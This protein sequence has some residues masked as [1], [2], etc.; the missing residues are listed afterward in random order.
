MKFIIKSIVS[1]ILVISMLLSASV[2]AFAKSEEIYLSELRIVYANSYDEAKQVLTSSK[3]EDYQIFNENLNNGSGEVGVW[4]AYKTTTNIED[5]ITDIAIM[6]MGGGYSEGNF[7]EMIKASKEEYTAMG[8]IYLEAID[9]FAEAYEAG[10][11]LAG[12]AYRQ[13]NFYAGLDNYKDERLGDLFTEGVLTSSDLAT[14]F[15]QGNSYVLRNIRSLLAMGV[16]YNKEGMHYLQRVSMIASGNYDGYVD[17]SVADLTAEDISLSDS[18]DLDVLTALIAP[19]ITVFRNMFEELAAYEAELNYDD[20]EFTEL[21]VEY[22]EYKAM[23]DMMRAVEYLDGQSLYDFCMNYAV[24]KNDYSAL[25]PLAKALNEG[26]VAMTKVAHYYDVVRY[27]MTESP[28][29]VI[30][31]QLVEL[32]AKYAEKAF[33]VYTGVDRDMY[34]G[35][36]AL[37]S[38]AYRA[39]AYTDSV[40]LSEALFG[41]ESLMMTS[42]QIAAGA[43][44]IGLSVW[45]IVRTAKG[46]FGGT[47]EVASRA[48]GKALKKLNETAMN[49]AERAVINDQWYN[50]TV[51]T[52]FVDE[53]ARSFITDAQANLFNGDFKYTFGNCTERLN[54]INQVVAEHPEA[55]ENSVRVNNVKDAFQAYNKAYN[56][57]YKSGLAKAEASVRSSVISARIFTGAL[58]IFGAASTA[59]SAVSLYNKIH[60]Y[61]NPT[62][63]VVPE[64]LVDLID[65]VDGD[66]YIKYDAVLEATVRDKKAGKYHPGDLNAY[67]A[68][69]WNAV[70]Y[71]KSYEAGKPLLA[72]FALSNVSNKA[73]EG[74]LPVH[75]FGEV[76]CYD[77]NKYNFKSSS[78]IIYLSVAQSENQKSAVADVPDI[79]GSV[80]GTGFLFLAGGLGLAIGAGATVG[81]QSVLKKK[82]ETE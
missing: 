11:F 8:D 41:D 36:F 26:Q 13:L 39:D 68:Q 58:Y 81:V 37:T 74:Y 55:F 32:E 46:G 80:F 82:K 30:N 61:Y 62:Y 14:L 9:Y 21:E 10:N 33:D 69:R 1:I 34:K 67:E 19:N 76:V 47:K 2:V 4:L 18:E 28:E 75:R 56:K 43:L 38:D 63:D 23:A 22:A 17:E 29:D 35:T 16:S 73:G 45:A 48:A 64:A 5:A 72:D 12:S 57:A 71:T 3:L 60:D 15:M 51:E 53:K 42:V 6:Q 25:Y 65:T 66:R 78:D 24:D 20:E 40:S 54:I 52:F 70:Y 79:V 44:G 7:Q 31:E 27:S 50:L 49:A 77:L 59:Y